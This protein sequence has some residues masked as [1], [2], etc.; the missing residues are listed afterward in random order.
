MQVKSF[1]FPSATGVCVINGSAFLPEENVKA[2]VAVHHGM[3]EHMERYADFITYLTSNGVAVFM[4]DMAN[5]IR[6]PVISAISGRKTA[7]SV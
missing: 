1:S 6:I 7:G 3:A 5:Q 2:A 4:H